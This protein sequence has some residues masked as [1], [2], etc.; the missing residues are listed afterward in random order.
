MEH[1]QLGT[2]DPRHS[3]VGEVRYMVECAQARQPVLVHL[4]P[5]VFF[6][7][8]TGDAWALDPGQGCAVCLARD[9]IKQSVHVVETD[10]DFELGW[11]HKYVIEDNAFVATDAHGTVL[12]MLNYPAREILRSAGMKTGPGASPAK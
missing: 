10:K 11:S 5:L 4:G 1:S 7:S 2:T 6:S 12:R 9:G 8:G 3:V